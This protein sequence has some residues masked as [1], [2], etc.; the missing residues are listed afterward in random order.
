MNSTKCER[1]G[2]FDRNRIGRTKLS[3]Y[4]FINTYRCNPC[5][6]VWQSQD[7]EV[8]EDGIDRALERRGR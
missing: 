1:C 8:D 5:G 4:E 2:K 3:A 6:A 7:I